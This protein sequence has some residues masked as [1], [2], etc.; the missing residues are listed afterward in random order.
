MED[1]FTRTEYVSNSMLSW[2]KVS[3]SY[4]Q[5]KLNKIDV[6]GSES[7]SLQL[8]TMIHMALLEP[9]KFVVGAADKPSG[10]M[11]AFCDA[12]LEGFTEEQARE[13]ADLKHS[14]ETILE[15]YKKAGQE[16]V[17]ERKQNPESIFIDS[18]L[19]FTIDKS[20]DAI[21]ANQNA[22][23]LLQEEGENE[24]E[25]YWEKEGIKKKCKVDKLI[26]SHLDDNICVNLDVKTTSSNVFNLPL[27]LNKFDSLI[28]VPEIDYRIDK[29]SFMYS[30]LKYG[31]HRQ[32]AM[33]HEGI[34]HYVKEKY[35]KNVDVLHVQIVINTST[36]D[37]A[38]YKFSPYWVKVGHKEIKDLLSRYKWH[39]DNN[40]W[41]FPREFENGIIKI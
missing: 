17:E 6:N 21:L 3:P 24:L 7:K 16:Y 27:K 35:D 20:I 11:G 41:K 31:Y 30:Y 29:S 32:Q 37:C 9:H 15:K 1:Y 8:G 4:F 14:L 12:L 33:Y 34:K 36:F 22:Y 26:T 39:L 38:V 5:K 28:Y 23:D 19:K 13:Q 2:L 25:I 10:K 18:S 40:N